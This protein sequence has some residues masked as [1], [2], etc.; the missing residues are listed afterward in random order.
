MKIIN[1]MAHEVDA[2]GMKYAPSG[3]VARVA[4]TLL[5]VDEIDGVPVMVCDSG[6]VQNCPPK[7]DGHIY[8]VSQYVRQALPE[9]KDL[10]SPTKL[11]RDNNGRVVGCGAFE[12]NK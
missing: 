12:R 8:I 6:A 10:V 2:C 5:K 1:Y 3:H 11:L 7:K 9:R 4:T